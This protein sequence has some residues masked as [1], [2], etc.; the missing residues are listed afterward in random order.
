MKVLQINVTYKYG[1]TG[2]IVADI[3]TILKMN[4]HSSYV[5][6]GRHYSEID[7][8]LIKIGSNQ[9]QFLHG[10]KTRLLDRHG[11]GSYF[12]T[13]KLVK[14]MKSINPDIIHLHN[15]HGYYLH[16]DVLFQFLKECK[17]PVVWTLHDTWAITGHCAYFEYVNCQKW[18]TGC[19]QCPQTK[20]YPKSVLLDASKKNYNDK[21]QLFAS[22][23]NLTIVTPS[24]QLAKLVEQSFLGKYAIKTIHNGIDLNVFKPLSNDYFKEIH[25]LGNKVIL[26]V[27]SKWEKRKG[28]DS[29]VQLSSMLDETY[30]IV[31]V[32]VSDDQKKSLPSSI[33]S[34]RR[35]S[36]I[37]ELAS[38]Y[39]SADVFVNPTLEDTFPTTNLESL[40]C[41]TPVIT[42][43]TGGSPESITKE[44]GLVVEKNNIKELHQAIETMLSQE[45]SAFTTS[46]VK[47]ATMMYNKDD[48]Y[49]D[50][51]HLYK[52]L[53]E[54]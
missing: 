25:A 32:G 10:L 46:C 18:I 24:T 45:K 21:R 44:T 41:G 42:Y 28:L 48:R 34:I 8:H 27:A 14:K 50:Y 43:K 40:A 47:H 11:F 15:V 38:I 5:A 16:I 33:K 52:S 23:P 12:E 9:S 4:G 49:R 30:Q 17:K 37:E 36:N 53:I 22:L 31:L 51:I 3:D 1:S 54:E 39:A 2:R 19:Y 7:E 6:Y 20:E 13:K 29:F 26:G 35:T